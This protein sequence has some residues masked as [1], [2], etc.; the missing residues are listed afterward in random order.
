MKEAEEFGE[1]ID[2]IDNLLAA[3]NIPI[4]AETHVSQ[5]RTSLKE[6]SEKLKKI[7]VKNEGENPWQE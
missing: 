2:S 5:M 7:Y 3:L 4:P 6:V 1:T